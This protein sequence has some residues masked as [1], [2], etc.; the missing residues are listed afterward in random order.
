MRDLAFATK[1]RIFMPD[2]QIL[3]RNQKVEE[4]CFIVEGTASKFNKKNRVLEQ[5]VEGQ[6][7]GEFALLKDVRP[8][9]TIRA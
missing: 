5:L 9:F 7:T 8:K 6:F 1:T 4:I 3:E 2:D